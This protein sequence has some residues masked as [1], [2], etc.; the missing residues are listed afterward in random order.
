MSSRRHASRIVSC[1]TPRMVIDM[2]WGKPEKKKWSLDYFGMVEPVAHVNDIDEIGL[3]RWFV[4]AV[5]CGFSMA[6]LD[7]EP[8][9]PAP[10]VVG[11][12]A[13]ALLSLIAHAHTISVPE[14]LITA[15]VAPQKL[16]DLLK[17]LEKAHYIRIDNGN[18]FS[19]LDNIFARH[20]SREVDHSE[21][22]YLSERIAIIDELAANGASPTV[23]ISH[24]GFGRALIL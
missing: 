23:T 9:L 6:L 4:V 22:P 5:L 21:A 7:L 15:Q 8:T 20:E 1:S 13:G 12:T 24:K 10:R 17:E 19:M 2:V 3:V 16:L 18:S 11:M 14:L